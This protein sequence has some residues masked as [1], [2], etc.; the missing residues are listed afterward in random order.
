M[1]AIRLAVFVLVLAVGATPGRGAEDPVTAAADAA[2][3]AEWFAA[4]PSAQGDRGPFSFV[5]GGA[6]YT[7]LIRNWAFN[8]ADR[9]Q[10]DRIERFMGWR[11]PATGLEV[12]LVA[13]L[14]RDFPAVEWVMSLENHGNEATPIVENILPLNASFAV[15]GG[16]PVLHYAK[17]AVCCLDDFAPQEKVLDAGEE[18]RL[19]P[20]GGRSSSEYLPLFNLQTAG[21]GVVLG[22]GWT[23]E[24]QATF[25][26]Q[27]AGKVRVRAGMAK[28]HLKLMPGEKI[29]TPR[30]LAL[31]WRGE[32]RLAGNNLLRRFLLAHHRPEPNGKPLVLPLL[33]GAWGGSPA[34]EHLAT[35]E[36]I[37][38][39]HLPFELYWIDAE[40]FG[41]APWW[42]HPGNWQVRED[43]YP[44]G[45][46]PLSDRLHAAGR[47]FLLW[48]E[49]QRVCE[50]TPWAEFASRPGWLLELNDGV[51]EYQ[52]HEMN[53]GVPH[54]DP[55]WIV[56]ESRRSKITAGDRLW[57]MGHADAR[58]FLTDFLSA[59]IDEFGM[60]WYRED[61]N[62]APLEYW[63]A[64]DA[65]DRQGMTEIR[66]V[67]GLYAMWDELLTRHPHLA[68]DNCASGGR[69]IDLETIGRATALW[70]TDWPVDALHKQCH[71]FG[72]LPWVPL[73]MSGPAALVAGNEYEIRSAMTAGLNAT[74]PPGDD[75]ASMAAAK[76][77]A[78]QYLGI[79][80]F[81]YGD[82]WPLTA[83][84][85]SQEVWMA[86][87]LDLPES[88][89]GLVVALR[90][91]AAG[92]TEQR[93]SLRGLEPDAAYLLE[94]LDTGR[95]WTQIGA[96]L[97]AGGLTIE[98][99]R[100]PDSALVRYRRK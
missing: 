94:D 39:H 97:A 85:Q 42:K 38:R 61:F 54:D 93:F 56:W 12:R 96:E 78:E 37:E 79:R 43:L 58:R 81:Y 60:D 5:Y 28:T 6:D 40:W 77:L 34:A 2:R 88:G 35:I 24:W 13:T 51:P 4:I 70:R 22:V 91:P 20:G 86:Y 59:K 95:T 46:R 29:R 44:A 73:H 69:R 64:A 92:E 49:P 90:R 36:R 76:R 16:D 83:Y 45:F 66:Y 67:T 53:W 1:N 18:L 14:F 63:Q 80:K 89:E 87:Q 15:E 25:D 48:V 52:Q 8:R 68:I 57:N 41:G 11:D 84:S 9:D 31:F 47:Q 21:G 74:L 50:G 27:E 72:L 10:P 33:L 100:Q 55:R 7:T 23:G 19:Q 71:S 65:P 98:R 32:D 3:A 99:A 75:E 82:Y 62:I 30:M 26:R 17:G